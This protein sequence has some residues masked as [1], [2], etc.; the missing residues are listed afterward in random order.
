MLPDSPKGMN[1]GRYMELSQV[2]LEMVVPIGI[3]MAVDYYLDWGHWAVVVGTI[4][5]FTGGLFHLI[6]LVNKLDK[7]S[8]GPKSD[9][10]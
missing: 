5:G 8:S 1:L 4:L 6:Q 9:T 3:G 10:K 2:G 7:D